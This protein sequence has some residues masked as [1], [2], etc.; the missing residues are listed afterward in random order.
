MLLLYYLTVT[1]FLEFLR[2]GLFCLLT[3]YSASSL[4]YSLR[5]TQL[6]S[7]KDISKHSESDSSHACE[8]SA[9]R[10]GSRT[11]DS[12]P[13]TVPLLSMLYSASVSD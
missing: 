4:L 6:H 8:W 11:L 3:A 13:W 5:E 2:G 12:S 9:C 7:I 10:E 1:D